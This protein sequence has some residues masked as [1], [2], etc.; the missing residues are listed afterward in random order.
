MAC[1]WLRD[2][3]DP[4]AARWN[5]GAARHWRPC[6]RGL[7]ALP[8]VDVPLLPY[9]PMGVSR[10]RAVLNGGG[11]VGEAACA[12]AESARGGE[13]CRCCRNWSIEIEKVGHGVVMTMG[14]GGVGK[15]TVASAIAVELAHRGHRVHLSTTDPAAHLSQH[16]RRRRS[17]VCSVSRIDPAVE[18]RRYSEQ[19][20]GKG[21]CNSG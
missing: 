18:T 4:A 9:A 15:T 14:K 12:I 20:I 13:S 6:P 8:R 2:R 16:R 1:S 3:S 10:L 17:A 19:V 11:Q 21:R 7:A 5:R